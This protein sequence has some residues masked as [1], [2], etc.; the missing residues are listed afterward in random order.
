M[1]AVQIRSITK[2]IENTE[3]DSEPQPVALN[4]AKDLY[5]NALKNAETDKA[6][7]GVSPCA[8]AIKH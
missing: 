4:Q 3:K 7:R 5:V 2:E 6:C 1:K 8:P